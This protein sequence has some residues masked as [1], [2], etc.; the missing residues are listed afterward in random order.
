[1]NGGELFSFVSVSGALPEP[2]CRH[3]FHKILAALMY[4]HGKGIAHRDLK[5]DNIL[6][7]ADTYDIK[8]ADFGF[9]MPVW[10]RD[11]SGMLQTKRGTPEYMAPEIWE[12]SNYPYGKAP[13]YNGQAVDLFALGVI[14]FNL[15]TGFL[16]FVHA[17]PRSFKE[18]DSY[19]QYFNQH[20]PDTFWQMHE[21]HNKIEVSDEFKD[22]INIMF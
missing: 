5:L 6:V 21:K 18:Q 4:L 15:M 1:M 22:M 12:Q 19:Y 14:L 16:P 7:D 10:G 13:G 17:Y 20:R 9:A 2:I 3:Y 8:I 11:G